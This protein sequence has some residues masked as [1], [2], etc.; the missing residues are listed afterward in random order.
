MTK[1]KPDHDA[2]HDSYDNDNDANKA[3][4]VLPAGGALASLTALGTVL[5]AVD[6]A[7][8]IG[9]SGMPMLQFKREG[10]GIWSFGQK[11]TVVEDG[12]RWAV[13]PTTFKR[14]Y[15]CFGNNNKVLGESLLSI[16]R[17]MPNLAELPDKGFPWSEQWTVNLKCIDGTDAGTE[18]TYK[19]TTTGGIQAVA[20][21][22][23]QIRDRLND[24]QHGGRV[25]PIVLL[26][27]DSYLHP[28]YGKVWTPTLTIVDWMLLNGPAPAPEPASSPTPA[29]PPRRRR[30]G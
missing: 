18:V 26:K 19:P 2:N 5:N 3:V 20:G 4:A 25:S 28:Q 15:I 27:K 12:S 6:T 22:I 21:L 24:D 23:E 1:V 11:R 7:S 16:S 30:L 10:S 17:E 13:N 8:V 14:G 9:R 29:E